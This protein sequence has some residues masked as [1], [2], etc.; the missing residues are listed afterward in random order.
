MAYLPRL[1]DART[2]LQDVANLGG[3]TVLQVVVDGHL[4]SH[5]LIEVVDV[6]RRHF[7]LGFYHINITSLIN[8][9]RFFELRAHPIHRGFG[10]GPVQVQGL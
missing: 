6:D 1:P 7:W 9:L 4:G 3:R 10:L 2:V 5:V 8:H